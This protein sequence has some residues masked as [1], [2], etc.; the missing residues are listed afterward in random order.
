MLRRLLLL[1]LSVSSVAAAQSTPV[2][3]L[4][5]STG[6][7]SDGTLEVTVRV[8]KGFYENVLKPH[9]AAEATLRVT[10]DDCQ[11][12]TFRLSDAG[13]VAPVAVNSQGKPTGGY[14]WTVTVDLTGCQCAGGTTITHHCDGCGRAF[15]TCSGGSASCG[16]RTVTVVVEATNKPGNAAL[17]L[18]HI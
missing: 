15:D 6:F 2:Q 12:Y 16:P 5:P 9:D 8:A 13:S 11:S 7:T 14:L 10:V 18:I 17:S 4:S 3:I 1:A